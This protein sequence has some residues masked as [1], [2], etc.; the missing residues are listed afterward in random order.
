VNIVSETIK[1]ETAARFA[2]IPFF[3]KVN[4]ASV[5]WLNLA[6]VMLDIQSI[7]FFMTKFPNV[8][9]LEIGSI[10]NRRDS[11]NFAPPI[12]GEGFL[13]DP[14]K[15]LVDLAYTNADLHIVDFTKLKRLSIEFDED[16]YAQAMYEQDDDS[17]SGGVPFR[18]LIDKIAEASNLEALRVN[19]SVPLAKL[20]NLTELEITLDNAGVKDFELNAPPTVTTLR[21]TFATGN[22]FPSLER[23]KNLKHLQSLFYFRH[24]QSEGN[25]HRCKCDAQ[26]ESFHCDSTDPH[27]EDLIQNQRHLKSLYLVTVITPS[28]VELISHLTT[29]ERLKI[30]CNLGPHIVDLVSKLPNLTALDIHDHTNHR[31]TQHGM[32]LHHNLAMLKILNPEKMVSLKINGDIDEEGTQIIANFPNL[33]VLEFYLD[34]QVEVVDSWFCPLLKLSNLETFEICRDRSAFGYQLSTTYISKVQEE[35]R[36]RN[37]SENDS[38]PEPFLSHQLIA[39]FIANN[40]RLNKVLFYHVTKHLLISKVRSWLPFADSIRVSLG[41]YDE[42]KEGAPDEENLDDNLLIDRGGKVAVKLNLASLDQKD[43]LRNL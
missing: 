9:K 33:R 41:R 31:P 22:G 42:Q 43:I 15:N 13:L 35:R 23:L 30:S 21:L 7:Q 34:N 14:L 32:P 37:E 5:T 2:S 6:D 29:L 24:K 1:T 19:F 40:K 28:Q 12:P 17:G 16:D 20:Q 38:I 25:V 11:W 26:L 27:W 3:A 18:H 10:Y 4:L 39:D 36:A 8:Q